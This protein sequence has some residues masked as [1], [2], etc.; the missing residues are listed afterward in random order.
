MAFAVPNENMNGMDES[1]FMGWTGSR[2]LQTGDYT[3]YS[4]YPLAKSYLRAITLARNVL[5]LKK[6]RAVMLGCSK[7]GAAVSIA[8]G[9][10]PE[11]VAGVMTTCFHGGNHMYMAALKFAQFGTDI[12][13]PAVNRTGPGFVPAPQLLRSLY[14]PTGLIALAYYDPYL[15]REKIKSSYFVVLG[16]NDEFF[17]LGTPNEMMNSLNGDKAFLAIDNTDHTYVSQKHLLAWRMW[18]EHNFKKRPVPEVLVE[19]D[20]TDNILLVNAKVT[21]QLPV[22]EVKLFYAYN[23]GTDWRFA[24]WESVSMKTEQRIFKGN[25]KLLE[26]QALGYYVQVRDSQDGIISSLIETI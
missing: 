22:K 21:S 11:R 1:D 8:T 5:Q 6:P 17:G 7:R 19:V 18:L 16:T 20:K 23:E 4:Y 15:W 2:M 3:W 9:I 13:G 10:D 12:G 25:L 14:N 24:T 26:K